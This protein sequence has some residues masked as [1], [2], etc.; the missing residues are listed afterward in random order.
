MRFCL[1]VSALEGA[2]NSARP[3]ESDLRSLQALVSE[4]PGLGAALLHVPAEARDPFLAGDTIPSL[5]LQLAFA[6]LSALEA[7]M[8]RASPLAALAVNAASFGIGGCELRHQAMVS[9]TFP[10]SEPLPQRDTYCSYLVGYHGEAE[11]GDAWLRHY[12]GQHT[13]L[14][15]KLPGIRAVE[16]LT[17]LDAVSELEWPRENALL[18]NRVMFDSSQALT[19]ALASPV[20]AEMRADYEA[21]PTFHGRVT[22]VPMLTRVVK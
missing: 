10:V 20:R 13:L 5:V 9:C 16:A 15:A 21:F 14:M 17:R 18:R 6:E 3:S 12:L 4:M 1:L 22:H 8:T 19:A 11:D 7:A 2:D